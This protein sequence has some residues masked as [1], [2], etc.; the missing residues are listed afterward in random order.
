[1]QKKV[2]KK[3]I[4]GENNIMEMEIGNFAGWHS[5]AHCTFNIDTHRVLLPFREY[6]HFKLR[7]KNQQQKC[8]LT[9]SERVSQDKLVFF[10]YMYNVI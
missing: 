4:K 9:T 1:M 2:N 3:N 7:N 6:S 10:I 5:L 8:L